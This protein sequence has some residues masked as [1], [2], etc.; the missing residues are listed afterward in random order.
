MTY[1]TFNQQME[2]FRILL[3]N[4][5]EDTI[6]QPRLETYGY[7]ADKLNEG[8]TLWTETDTLDKQYD[9]EFSE[10]KDATSRF[11]E[12]WDQAEKKLKRAKKLARIAFEN[13]ANAWGQLNLKT[14]NIN[15]FE[16]W[17]KDAEQFYANLI[18][19]TDWAT[20]MQTFG[21]TADQLTADQQEIET[22]K[23]LQEEQHREMGDAQQVT[24]DKWEKFKLL[25]D[26]CDTLKEIAIIEFEDDA[27]YLEKLGIL[28][29]S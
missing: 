26:W 7:T 29:R 2:A 25:K 9:Q 22:L 23:T 14:L 28:A 18:G 15:R 8:K 12:T 20:A 24:K 19:N 5:S 13:N 4:A 1:L 11:N 10:Q 27:Q 6:I 3:W 17:L 21:Y 16:D